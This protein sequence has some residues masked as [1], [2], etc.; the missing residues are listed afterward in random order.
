MDVSRWLLQGGSASRRESRL[1]LG[2]RRQEA[3]RRNAVE[4]ARKQQL[5]ALVKVFD[6]RKE[7][8][9]ILRSTLL[10]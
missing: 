6:R 5:H 4:E 2:L 8:S 7:G 10:G 3:G 9:D 1:R